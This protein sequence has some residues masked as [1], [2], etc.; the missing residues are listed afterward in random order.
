[1]RNPIVHRVVLIRLSHLGEGEASAETLYEAAHTGWA[2]GAVRRTGPQATEVAL[3][4]RDDA[5]V[6]AWWI[7]GWWHD[8]DTARWVFDGHSDE[9][10]DERYL[11]LD[12]GRWYPKGS[13]F[14]L[15]YVAPGEKPEP[16]T[17]KAKKA[18]KVVEAPVV[19]KHVPCPRCFMELPSSGVCVHCTE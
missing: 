7:D 12:V 1:M 4:V 17:A 8:D 19:E 2:V 6:A 13:R 11:G 14:S 5:V 3:A 10:L 9:V 15:R 18:T 16:A